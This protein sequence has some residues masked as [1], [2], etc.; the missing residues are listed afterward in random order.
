MGRTCR[1]RI[2]LDALYVLSSKP[3]KELL[4]L[5][6]SWFV[7]GG[8][9]NGTVQELE[10]YLKG[11]EVLSLH[12]RVGD[13]GFNGVAKYQ[14]RPLFQDVRKCTRLVD[15]YVSKSLST[16]KAVLWFLAS[17]NPTIR[18]WFREKFPSKVV[19][20]MHDPRHL[21]SVSKMK[22]K[23]RAQEE[24]LNMFAEWYL[25][26]KGDHLIVNAAHERGR[27]VSS[28][29]RTAWLYTLR[30]Q[31]YL[32]RDY[33]KSFC[34]KQNFRLEGNINVARGCTFANVRPRQEHLRPLR[35]PKA[36]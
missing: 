30:S 11:H 29:S 10:D 23:G 14:I 16:E 8:I 1:K 18:A 2:C 36:T 22:A 35:K 4:D 19:V 33:D 6:I 5:R 17:D 32:V 27:G 21:S 20:L 12:V 3:T 25:L 24:L 9:V 28:F 26:G 13:Q 34:I 15:S 7:N 31:H